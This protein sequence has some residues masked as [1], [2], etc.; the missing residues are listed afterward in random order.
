M[1]ALDT[2]LAYYHDRWLIL[3]TTR[4]RL[5]DSPKDRR[6]PN[7]GS[8]QKRSNLAPVRAPS[9]IYTPTLNL[10]RPF[11]AVVFAP[12]VLLCFG[13]GRRC[14]TLQSITCGHVK[15]DLSSSQ[16]KNPLFAKCY[17]NP[18]VYC[19]LS[20]VESQ[21]S[22]GLTL[23]PPATSSLVPSFVLDWQHPLTL[24][25]VRH[26]RRR[27]TRITMTYLL[28]TSP[29]A[30]PASTLSSKAGAPFP[31]LQGGCEG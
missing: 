6:F 30:S 15:C 22:S 1:R 28:K 31:G 20:P 10:R 27:T 16:R 25:V 11:Y 4:A 2:P 21:A 19:P 12:S 5:L 8:H 14:S 13:R 26:C 3:L 23:P 9:C 24:V 18:R 7:N 29:G 17:K